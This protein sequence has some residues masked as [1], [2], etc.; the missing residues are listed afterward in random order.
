MD[1]LRH[2]KITALVV[3]LK[4]FGDKA[5]AATRNRLDIT[6]SAWVFAQRLPERKDMM[7]E[8]CLFHKAVGPERLHQFFLANHVT[9][10]GHKLDQKI[11]GFGRKRN[12]FSVAQQDMLPDI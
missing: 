2:H 7:R 1:T 11:E 6:R 12:Y 10:V 5:V 8:V 3:R 4:N 9:A